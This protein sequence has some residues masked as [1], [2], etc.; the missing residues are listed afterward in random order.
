M[1]TWTIQTLFIVTFAGGESEC[2]CTG[3]SEPRLWGPQSRHGSIREVCK[4][5]PRFWQQWKHRHCPGNL[6]IAQCFYYFNFCAWILT[7]VCCFVAFQRCA[8]D[9]VQPWAA[10]WWVYR[11]PSSSRG[12]S[13]WRIHRIRGRN[14]DARISAQ[15]RGR[16]LVHLRGLP[17][18]RSRGALPRHAFPSAKYSKGIK[19]NIKLN[20]IKYSYD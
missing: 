7:F 17:K 8:R 18:A 20:Y 5:S 11:F 9:S 15:T 16:I 4:T 12:P 10:S 13:V 1:C 14:Q 6:H 19:N 3:I 2:L